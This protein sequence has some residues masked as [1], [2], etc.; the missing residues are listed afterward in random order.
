L[1]P[2]R[3]WWWGQRTEGFGSLGRI[4]EEAGDYYRRRSGHDL[5]LVIVV[6]VVTVLGWHE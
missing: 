6:V 5:I 4:K 3:R 2:I 1:G